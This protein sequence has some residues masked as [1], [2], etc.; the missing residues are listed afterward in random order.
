MAEHEG[1]RLMEIEMARQCSDALSTMDEAKAVA[2]QI[3]EAAKKTGRMVLYGIG[4][5]HYVDRMV[6]PLY[7]EAGIECR[8][9]SPSE[10]LMA[11]LPEAARVALFVSQSG[12]SGEIV[13]LLQTPVAL[14]RRFALTL[15]RD[16]TLGRSAE[17]S[18]V[19]SGGPENAFAAS[20]S[21]I[22]TIAM[23]AAILEALGQPQDRLRA[24][25]AADTPVDLSAITD[26][27][28]PS[29]VVVFAGRHV[30]QGAAQSAALSL[31]EL[32]RVPAIGLESGQ[33]R[34]GPFEFLRPGLAIVLLRSAG[35]DKD[36]IAP[37]A[38]T[39]VAA[40]CR[41]VV[42]DASG[43]ELIEGCTRVAFPTDA[44]LAA[45][46]SMLLALQ[47]LNVAVALRHIPAGVGTPRFTSKVTI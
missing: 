9:M 1:L 32:A 31:M 17:A 41:T 37:I 25:F 6:E 10:A 2:A 24:V 29:D 12:E 3:A 34:H 36:S 26:E 35:P 22:L 14:D 21:I 5:S 43:E 15:N 19:A 46:T 11:P 39:C 16:S 38:K 23:H 7:R 4:G 28:Y 45:A 30:L 13:E 42:L 33:F 20:R 27:L 8:A 18:I 47:R 40:G 44:G